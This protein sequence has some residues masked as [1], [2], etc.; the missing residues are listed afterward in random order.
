MWRAKRITADAAAKMQADSGIVVSEFDVTNPVEP[1]DSVILFE[2]TGDISITCVPE[3][4]DFFADVNNAMTNTKE[5][6]RIVGWT[7]GLTVTSLSITQETLK[8]ALGAADIGDD[9]GI[10]PRVQYSK[11]DFKKIYWLGDMFDENKLFVIAMDD[12]V[13]T[14]GVSFTSTNNGKGGMDLTFTPHASLE[15]QDQVPM[16]FYILEKVPTDD[17]AAGG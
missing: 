15:K 12:T 7:C 13:S 6:K 5:G 3:T 10:R 1:D 8:V 11:E 16:A 17:E 2:T 4:E 14:S 9:G